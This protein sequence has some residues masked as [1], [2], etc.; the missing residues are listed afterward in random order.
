MDV[1]VRF[2]L[3]LGHTLP[4]QNT[5]HSGERDG[6][7]QYAFLDRG[8]PVRGDDQACAEV[9][10]SDSALE[11]SSA[12]GQCLLRH[13]SCKAGDFT[14]GCVAGSHWGFLLGCRRA[15]T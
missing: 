10:R 7:D 2:V 1:D 5:E 11:S 15:G 13:G 4:V 14:E 9:H 8:F 12:I 3:L 6:G